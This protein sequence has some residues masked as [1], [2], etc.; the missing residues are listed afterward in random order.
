MWVYCWEDSDFITF[1]MNCLAIFFGISRIIKFNAV[2]VFLD[3]NVDSTKFISNPEPISE[4]FNKGLLELQRKLNLK[5]FTNELNRAKCSG[6]I[7]SK[8]DDRYLWHSGDTL[9]SSV[10][11]IISLA[12]C[13]ECDHT[14][15]I[16]QD[17]I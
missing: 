8:S 9:W 15:L 14:F 2:S 11:L 5:F 13:Y 10:K 1:W 17:L 12:L 7:Q 4:L 3:D 16:E 6:V